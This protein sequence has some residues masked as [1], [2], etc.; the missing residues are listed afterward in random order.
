MLYYRTP[1]LTQI[2]TGCPF[3]KSYD[4]TY[5]ALATQPG[6][7][8]IV[9]GGSTSD[10]IARELNRPI[11]TPL[12]ALDPEV[13]AGSEIPGIELVT[14]GCVTLSKVIDLLRNPGPDAR[15]NPAT[16]MRDILLASDRILIDVGTAITYDIVSKGEYLGGNIAPG[17]QMRL[18]ALHSFTAKLPQ[19]DITT[20]WKE[21]GDDTQTAIYSGCYS[22]ILH[23][24]EGSYRR[25]S[26]KFP[27]LLVFLT[28]GG[29][30]YFESNIK[31]KIFAKE[32]LL[33]IG[34]NRILNDKCQK[35]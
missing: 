32:N 3:D 35:E 6:V 12:T 14:E 27:K 9:S 24:I 29:A 34:L 33:R 7:K 19:V 30:K 11:E 18:N 5:A 25:L 31:I 21:I 2:L 15:V 23:E 10:L 16:K 4:A 1:R 17:M 28:G 13:P 8:T 20:E 26:K 22:G